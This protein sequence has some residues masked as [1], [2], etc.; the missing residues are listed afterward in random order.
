MPALSDTSTALERCWA[1]IRTIHPDVRQ[2]AITVYLPPKEGVK[3]RWWSQAWLTAT[4]GR[5]DDVHISSS[6]LSKG[7]R[8][9][10]TTL[11]HEAV[12][13]FC[14]AKGIKEV[15]RQGR[16]HNERFK[17]TAEGFGLTVERRGSFGWGTTGI[18]EDTA[19][20]FKNVI[21]DLDESI[22]MWQEF[23]SG[24]SV[25][26][27]KK[28]GKG[29]LKLVCLGCNRIIRASKRTVQGGPIRC[30]PCGNDF[31]EA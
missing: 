1:A 3:G 28:K 29:M 14:A 21:D 26:A 24:T 20:A 22:R 9:T 10:F 23:T 5:I 4:E 2:A 13:S 25:A 11:L 15:S 6:L 19:T 7:G 30:V 18:T 27:P 16:Y 8:T 31:T 12:H 17:Q